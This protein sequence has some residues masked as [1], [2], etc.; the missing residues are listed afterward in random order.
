MF[1]NDKKI[2]IDFLYTF[3]YAGRFRRDNI[4]FKCDQKKKRDNILYKIDREIRILQYRGTVC[5]T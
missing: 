3:V 1:I 2:I 5:K 4:G